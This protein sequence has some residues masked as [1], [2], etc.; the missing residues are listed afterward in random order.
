MNSSDL[1]DHPLPQ[2]FHEVREPKNVPELRVMMFRLDSRNPAKTPH[3]PRASRAVMGG[4]NW[5]ASGQKI[6]IEPYRRY[7]TL[8]ILAVSS[9]EYRIQ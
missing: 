9:H 1:K 2:R 7:R 4:G 3:V 5:M 6:G 8:A